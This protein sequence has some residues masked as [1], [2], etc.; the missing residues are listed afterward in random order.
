MLAEGG[1]SAAT[2]RARVTSPQGTTQA[3]L[4][5]FAQGDLRELVRRAMTAATR[6]GGELSAMLD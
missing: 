3:A 5:A 4:D 2:L 1:E 6:R